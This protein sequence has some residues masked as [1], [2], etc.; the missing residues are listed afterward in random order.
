MHPNVTAAL[1]AAVV[2]G[3]SA[4]LVANLGPGPKPRMIHVAT[5]SGQTT[6][7]RLAADQWPEIEQKEVDALTDALKA[8]P[9]EARRD[10]TIFC[11]S[12]TRCGDLALNLENS[13]ESARWT[14]ARKLIPLADDHRGVM[15]NDDAVRDV[16]ASA[17]TLKPVKI[18]EPVAGGGI[19]III[20]SKPRT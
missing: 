19:G 15:V 8:V 5:S 17:T 16:L 9:R 14:V 6:V 11:H 13:F 2:G 10:V 1:I 20:G 4:F 18:D 7:M 3:A 12:D